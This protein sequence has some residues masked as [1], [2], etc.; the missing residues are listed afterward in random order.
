MTTPDTT[1]PGGPWGRAGAV[2]APYTAFSTDLRWALSA[3]RPYRRGIGSRAKANRELQPGH[4]VTRYGYSVTLAERALPYGQSAH[5]CA[6][7]SHL[8]RYLW[9]AWRKGRPAEAMAQWWCHSTTYSNSFRLTDEP[10]RDL[11]PMCMFNLSRRG[12]G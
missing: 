5:H 2:G 1:Q 4:V 11:C 12:D 6:K 3:A 7:Y 9:I 8:T 10:R